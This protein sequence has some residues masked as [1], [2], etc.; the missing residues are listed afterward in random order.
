MANEKFLDAFRALD[1]ELKSDGRSVMDYENSLGTGSLEQEKLK[2]CRI[3]RN[4]MAHNDT[5]FL[6]ATQ[7][8]IKFLDEQVAE[9][10]K[11]AHTVKDEMKRVKAVKPTEPIKNIIAAIDKFPIL[12]IDN[13][14]GIYLVDKDILIHNLAAGAKKITIP[15]RL[16]KYNYVSKT[17]RMDN[18]GKGTYIVTDDGTAGG[19]C[20][21]ILI[22]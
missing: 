6:A 11:L 19:N 3:M 22:S 12:P 2:V 17:D 10:R 5:T 4:Y 14:T 8:Q 1:T 15:A 18:I 21:G 13:K 9:I 16:P 7:E 20:L